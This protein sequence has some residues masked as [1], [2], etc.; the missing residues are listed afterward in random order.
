MSRVHRSI[1]C[2]DV[3][4]FGDPR[5]TDD[6]RA[7]VR[8]GLY[9]AVSEAFDEAG[10]PWQDCHHEDRGDGLLVLVASEVAKE[11]LVTG[12]P[13]R[14]AV[15]LAVHNRAEGPRARIR[16]RMAVH[17]GEIRHDAHGVI[18]SAINLAFRL[19]DAAPVKRVLAGSSGL[20]ALV[21]SDWFYTEVVRHTPRSRPFSYHRIRVAE[22]ETDTVAWV[23][24]PDDP[25]PD[26]ARLAAVRAVPPPDDPWS[27]P[28][29][30]PAD[31]V[32]FTGRSAELSRLLAL[33][34]GARRPVGAAMV[35]AIDGMAGIGKTALAVHAAHRLADRFTDGCLFLDLHGYTQSVAPLSPAEALERLLR[36]LGVPGRRIPGGVDERAALYRGRLAG[37]RT[38]IV[39]DN[40]AGAEHVR[41]LLPA[42]PNCLVLVT[43]RRRLA[44]L[45]ETLP[46]SLDVLGP[47]DGLAL[48]AAS[49]GRRLAGAGERAAARQ[50]VDLCGRLPLAIRIATARLRSRPAWTVADLAR[51]LAERHGALAR[52]DDGERDV[53]AAFSLSYGALTSGQRRMFR[54]FALHPGREGGTHAA[55]A[56]AGT[57]V[58]Q[59]ER[60]CEDLLDAHLLHQSA[61]GRYGYHDLIRDFAVEAAATEEPP[62]RCR[63]AVT[64]LLDHY[65][66]TASAAMRVLYPDEEDRRPRVPATRSPVP[67]VTEPAAAL[68]W[69]DVERPNLVAACAHG[70]AHG[71]PE[72]T[73][74]L[75]AVLFRYL[76]V[77]GHLAD[78]EAV[79]GHA[80]QAAEDAGDRTS[81]AH[82]LTSLGGVYWNQG[83]YEHAAQAV[84]D[85]LAIFQATGDRFGQARALGNL[86]LIYWRQGRYPQA[87]DHSRQALALHR[88]S[89]DLAGQA[90]ALG[91][92]GLV[93]WRQGENGKAI[94]AVRQAMACYGKLG[95]RRGEARMLG[96]LGNVRHHQGRHAQAVHHHRRALALY[97]E[98]GD[99]VGEADALTNLGLPLRRQGHVQQAAD[100]HREALALYRRLG[101][102]NGQAR[103]LNGLAEALTELGH[104]AR[105]RTHHDLALTFTL[106]TG[107]PYEQARAHTGLAITHHGTAARDHAQRAL[108]IYTDLGVPEAADPVAVVGQGC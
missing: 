107:D 47:A 33:G 57:T 34:S 89:G 9:R 7:V 22:K 97:R 108:A 84:Q 54:R 95:D 56:L 83:R 44:S 73:T 80:R 91:N 19:L 6:D 43:S 102:R 66:A 45:D 53:A 76:D 86:G 64:S 35:G 96:N 30:L 18:G 87:A 67:P 105:A 13:G 90:R 55:A 8:D 101:D 65:V 16:L 60:L 4:G 69:L 103:A 14:L 75:A 28:W 48:L 78:A 38:L 46:I 93:R 12:L 27:P 26:G 81:E 49:A 2:L 10:V 94:R 71:W 41:P 50:V 59:A 32:H 98:L 11:V 21:A 77:G 20:L 74:R 99:R 42:E 72:R 15:K 39:L 82:V 23:C 88:G 63:A 17:A 36:A 1:V 25:S 24:L 61:P 52:L 62:D 5:R 58:A 79:Y 104:T 106:G 51:S 3:E 70:T 68:A 37:S 31:T 29:Q 85:A 92:L 40:A 100:H